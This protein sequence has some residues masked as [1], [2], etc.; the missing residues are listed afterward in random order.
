MFQHFVDVTFRRLDGV[1]EKARYEFS[2]SYLALR[3]QRLCE[4]QEQVERAV[5][6]QEAQTQ[7]FGSVEE[8]AH[9]LALLSSYQVNIT[10]Y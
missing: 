2:G 1:N 6:V 4:N 5:Y 8:A 10:D 7:V 9:S 3:F